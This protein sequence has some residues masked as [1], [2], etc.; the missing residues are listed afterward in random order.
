MQLQPTT[1]TEPRLAL[2]VAE[3]AKA[4]GLSRARFYVELSEGRISGKKVGSRTLIPIESL[5]TWLAA[6]PPTG[7]EKAA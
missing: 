5:Q 6:L 3:A 2:T 7:T 1:K 4:I